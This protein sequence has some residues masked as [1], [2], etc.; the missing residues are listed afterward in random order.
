M[1]EFVCVC[2]SACMRLCL[3]GQRESWVLLSEAVQLG[4]EEEEEVDTVKLG[5]EVE[6]TGGDAVCNIRLVTSEPQL[7]QSLLCILCTQLQHLRHTGVC[8]YVSGGDGEIE[9]DRDV[10]TDCIYYMTVK[11][12][13]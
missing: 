7:V 13:T 10:L 12:V 6:E 4:L 2:L 5:R 1:R 11:T 8:V 3:T 9:G